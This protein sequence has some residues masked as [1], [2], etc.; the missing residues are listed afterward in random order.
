MRDHRD[1]IRQ[2]LANIIA[3]TRCPSA[4]PI[5]ASSVAANEINAIIVCRP[6]RPVASPTVTGALERVGCEAGN[7][8]CG[9][10][11]IARRRTPHGAVDMGICT[12]P[13]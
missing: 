13:V 9:Q 3:V 8:G 1:Q 6:T 10:I 7:V 4:M 5:T 11:R 12:A 2:R